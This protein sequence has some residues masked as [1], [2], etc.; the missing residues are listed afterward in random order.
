V[1]NAFL[2]PFPIGGLS[3]LD[4]ALYSIG[5][6]Q[7]SIVQYKTA[8]KSNMFLVIARCPVDKMA[9]AKSVPKTFGAANVDVHRGMLGEFMG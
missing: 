9:K 7:D 4:A 3:P 6:R 1:L 5:I 8:I 2:R